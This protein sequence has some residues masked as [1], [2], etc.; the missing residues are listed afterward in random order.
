MYRKALKPTLVATSI[1]IVG[2]VFLHDMC[3][4]A[5]QDGNGAQRKRGD[6]TFGAE[7]P[8]IKESAPEI[9]AF[10]NVFVKVADAVV[11][12]VVSVIPTKV[13]TVLF[14]RNPFYRFFDGE[15]GQGQGNNPFDFFFGPPQQGQGEAPVQKRERRQQGLGSGVIVSKE[16]YIL[17]NYHVIAGATEIEV[18]LDDG[19]TF[20]AEITGSDS[21]SDVAVVKITDDIPKD[22]PVAYLGDSDELKA[23]NWVVAIGNPFSLTSTVTSGIVSALGRQIGDLTM[24]QNF[25][26]TDAAINPGNSGGAL[27]NIQGELVGI[28]TIIYSQTG[29]FMGI[30]FAIPI[31]MAQRVMEDLIFEGKVTRGWIGVTIQQVTPAVKQALGLETNNGVLISDVMENQPADKAGIRRGDVIVSINNSNVEGP[32]DLRNVVASIRPGTTVP[33]ELIRE[34]KRMKVDLTVAERTPQVINQDK[35]EQQPGDSPQPER[36]E[37]D[38]KTGIAVTNITPQNRR[39]YNLPQN[40]TGAIITK[41]DPKAI[42]T[43]AGLRPGDVIKQAKVKGSNTQKIESAQDFRQF[44]NTL[45]PGQSVLLLVERNRNTFYVAFDVGE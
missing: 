41:I 23:G 26:Q 20:D 33:V 45:K 18:R 14:Y 35:P 12:S 29:G 3:S 27:V 19:R 24:Y 13:D 36:G 34:G 31:N 4:Y 1:L 38:T 21:L 5:Q 15:E 44:A 32:N 9:E 28:N 6:I 39:Q 16:G 8:P 7:E 40:I 10:S 37:V 17:T 43:R 2:I 42:D 25:I 30:G 22:L 11:P